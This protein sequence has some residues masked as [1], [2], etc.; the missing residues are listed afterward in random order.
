MKNMRMNFKKCLENK[1]IFK[2]TEVK[3]LVGKEI[4]LAEEDLKKAH[5]GYEREEFRWPTIQCYYSM[6]HSTRALLYLKGYRERSHICLY[7]AMEELYVKKGL[8]DSEI[9]EVFKEARFLREDADYRGD[10]S[11][12][13]LNKLLDN[14]RKMLKIAK[15]IMKNN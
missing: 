15:S 8:I 13:N 3:Y 4:K 1:K 7:I 14:S 11:Q 10:F 5:E 12:E 2:S 9:V 6:F